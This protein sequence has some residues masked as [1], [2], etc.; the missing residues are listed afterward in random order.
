VGFVD[1]LPYLEMLGLEAEAELVITDSG[2][3][4][5]ETTWLGVPCVTV[6]PNT[7]RPLTC[8]VGTNRLVPARRDR[9]LHAAHEA[10]AHRP[11]TAPTIEHWDGLAADRLA[12]VL[13]DG[14]QFV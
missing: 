3:L 5:E 11:A 1:P 7:E 14:A 2:G 8:A 13:C 9:I 4:Q 6:R 12:A 10:R